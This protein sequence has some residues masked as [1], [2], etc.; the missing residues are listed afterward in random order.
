[1]A[2]VQQSLLYTA[3]DPFVHFLVNNGVPFNDV[4]CF[5]TQRHLQ[6]FTERRHNDKHIISL[7]THKK[8]STCFENS[9]KEICECHSELLRI[10]QLFA[11]LSHNSNLER[12]LCL[13][14][15]KWT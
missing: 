6:G 3:A 7:L 5:D 13:M 10:S 8:R 1:M 2:L 9:K 11:I 15:T 12:I 4:K 14:K